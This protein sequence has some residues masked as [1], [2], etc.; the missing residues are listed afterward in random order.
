MLCCHK[1]YAVA[2]LRIFDKWWDSNDK[3]VILTIDEYY[4]QLMDSDASYAQKMKEKECVEN[5][6]LNYAYL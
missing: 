3:S 6:A 1:I 4:Q 2:L 5:E